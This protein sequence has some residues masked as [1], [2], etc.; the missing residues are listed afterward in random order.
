MTEKEI[1]AAMSLMH[2]RLTLSE[3]EAIYGN[4]IVNAE[5]Q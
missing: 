1:S 2:K 4:D 3:A 5:H